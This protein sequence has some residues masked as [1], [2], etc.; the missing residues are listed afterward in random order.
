MR[1]F[2]DEIYIFKLKQENVKYEQN[3][4]QAYYKLQSFQ[5]WILELTQFDPSTSI[6]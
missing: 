5:S 2:F 6:Q 4:L 1:S 3:L